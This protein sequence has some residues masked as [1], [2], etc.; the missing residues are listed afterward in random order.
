MTTNNANNK[1]PAMFGYEG[2][3]VIGGSPNIRDAFLGSLECG[4]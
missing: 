4:L 3:H 2:A 1:D